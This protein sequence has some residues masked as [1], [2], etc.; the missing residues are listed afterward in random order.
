VE[1]APAAELGPEHRELAEI[2]ASSDEDERPDV[3]E[4]LPVDRF[5]ELLGLLPDDALVAVAAE[6]ELHPALRDYWEDV[7]ASFHDTDAHHLYVDPERLEQSLDERAALRLSSISQDQPHQFRAQSADRAARSLRESQAGMRGVQALVFELPG[8]RVQLSMNLFRV[9]E[10]PPAAVVAEL[11]R[12]GVAVGEQQLVGLTPAIAANHV[13]AGRS[14]QSDSRRTDAATSAGDECDTIGEAHC[15][16]QPSSIPPELSPRRGDVSAAI[17]R[18]E[19][20][21]DRSRSRL[22]QASAHT[23]YRSNQ[24]LRCGSVQIAAVKVPASASR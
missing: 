17:R 10:T 11:T 16:L 23:D 14:K 8:G 13:G 24:R 12:R 19:P 22:V 21:N 20:S 3:A 5:G 18:D 6:E 1:I 4:V 15:G 9:D 7:T 2:A